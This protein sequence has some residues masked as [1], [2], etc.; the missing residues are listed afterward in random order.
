MNPINEQNQQAPKQNK[1]LMPVLVAAG[2]FIFVILVSLLGIY[3]LT[4]QKAPTG[5][6]PI[7]ITEVGAGRVNGPEVSIKK[8]GDAYVV[9]AQM[10]IVIRTNEE[11]INFKNDT[12]MTIGVFVPALQEGNNLKIMAGATEGFSLKTLR[13]DSMVCVGNDKCNQFEFLGSVY[14]ALFK[15]TIEIVSANTVTNTPTPTVTIA[16]TETPTPS[17]TVPVVTITSIQTNNQINLLPQS[18]Y[19]PNGLGTAMVSVVRNSNGYWDFN[20]ESA[21]F[22]SLEPNRNY[23]LWICNINCSSNNEAKFT[24]DAAG[25]ASI[26]N[27]LIAGHNQ[28]NDPVSRVVVYEMPPLGQ[29]IPNDPKACFMVGTNSTPC[30]RTSYSAQ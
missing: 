5:Q 29:E 23:Q 14:P 13:S 19:T 2:I 7:E 17:P 27:V 12:G 15:G 11:G 1:N 28:N 4:R 24:T 8:Q 3:L 18:P 30:L 9:D 20:F 21:T 16:L 26:P 25:N 10:P 22:T 6:K